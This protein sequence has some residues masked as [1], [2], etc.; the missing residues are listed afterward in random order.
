MRS[1]YL[2]RLANR[3]Y[4]IE[5][6]P[7]AYFDG[8]NVG[9]GVQ[10]VADPARR[11]TALL[12]LNQAMGATG[13]ERAGRVE[14]RDGP[15]AAF[16]MPSRPEDAALRLGWTNEQLRV[17]RNEINL[18]DVG[19]LKRRF[20]N[21]FLQSEDI[22]PFTPE[23]LASNLHG[24]TVR[25]TAFGRS[26]RMGSQT[27]SSWQRH[28]DGHLKSENGRASLFLM[29][30]TDEDWDL[31]ARN[32]LGEL[33]RHEVAK[34]STSD[35]MSM[36]EIGKVEGGPELDLI[37]LRERIEAQI[38]FVRSQS[39]LSGRQM[40]SRVSTG[41]PAHEVRNGRK[42]QLAQFST[43]PAVGEIAAEFLGGEGRRV[44]EPTIG[45][46]V[47][48]AAMAG[49]GAAVAGVEI[50]P[51]RAARAR[52][53]L[54][55]A[56]VIEGDALD[57]ASYP[58]GLFDAVV[59]NPPF[60]RL[61][62][63][64]RIEMATA[65]RGA[66]GGVFPARSK[67]AAVLLHSINKLRAGGDA[68]FVMPGERN[69]PSTLT[70]EK[71][72]LQN[73]LVSSFEEVK[74]ISLDAHLYQAMGSNFPVLVHFARGR[75]ADGEGRGPGEAARLATEWFARPE[76]RRFDG[77]DREQAILF[78]PTA[79]SFEDFYNFADREVL[80]REPA[81]RRESVSP[82]PELSGAEPIPT[83]S[84]GP[85]G[86]DGQDAGGA[87]PASPPRPGRTALGSDP[88]DPPPA[89]ASPSEEEAPVEEVEEAGVAWDS[90]DTSS[91]ADP[92]WY[93]DD[94]TTD[95]FT[96]PYVPLSANAR[97]A[98]TVIERT[99]SSGTS[100]A[101]QNAAL[102]IEG[103]IDAY[104]A[105]KLGISEEA[106]L[107][108]DGPLSPEQIDSLALTFSRRDAGLASI[109]GDQMGVGKGRQLAAHAV[110][111]LMQEDRPVLFMSN[112]Q[113]LFTDFAVRDLAAVSGRSFGEM[114]EGAGGKLRPFIM[115]AGSALVDGGRPIFATSPADQ[116]L[117]RETENLSGYNL[118]M[119]TY[120]QV[121]LA[122]GAW[123]ASALMNWIRDNTEAGRPPI[124]L[125]D[126]VH[127]AAGPD[128]RTGGVI[129]GVVDYAVIHDAPI[130]YSSAT[131]VKSGRNLPVYAP[132][133]PDT[134]LTSQELLLAIDKMPLAMQEILSSEMA[135]SGSLIERKMSDAGVER[136][137]VKLADLDPGKMLAARRA[138]DKVSY[139]LQEMQAASEDI[140]QA[141]R[142]QFKSMV[143]G[144]ASAGSL[145]KLQVDTTSPAT[146]L[147]AFSRYLMGSVKGLYTEELMV[148]AVVNN[149]KAT[150]VVEFTGDSVAEWLVRK[151]GQGRAFT[152]NAE[153][154]VPDHPNMGHVLERFAERMLVVK[155]V[156][157]YGERHDFEIAGF[158]GWLDRIKDQIAE[159]QLGALRINIFDR[160]RE[161]GEATG[162]TVQDISGRSWEFIERDGE[163]RGAQA[164][165]P[166]LDPGRRRLQRGPHGR[167]GVQL[168]GRHRHLAPE[169]AAARRGSP[170]PCDDQDGLPARDHR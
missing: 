69:D 11:G 92:T 65:P 36:L 153:I 132:A 170:S 135:K 31:L 20:V 100:Q 164:H 35:L 104:V 62:A 14:L 87:D 162:Q 121:Q 97:G 145:D 165:D 55:G 141:A 19:A 108:E 142:R 113:N 6:I 16:S 41:F 27:H 156:D 84:G 137:L 168:V 86:T 123:R 124:L 78:I 10:V 150:V 42:H 18:D 110:N 119:A 144:T 68:V 76:H 51:A 151:H 115:N 13:S 101:L 66:P 167:S 48:V 117:A 105:G 40:M 136:S 71:V 88:E 98:R 127:K 53:A 128:S 159:A 17:E 102:G 47:F 3:D 61:D 130:V 72:Q 23:I 34:F 138:S 82:D 107:A 160:V 56:E 70:G 99:M 133:L 93:V 169:L 161:V 21:H 46:G 90:V 91:W 122:S 57:P 67:Q 26:F 158:D 140:R 33:A 29:A 24:A 103:T 147:D 37:E 134:G 114:L 106:I 49:N 77:Q 157:G 79:S 74:T 1:V 50:D 152:G 43:P 166:R 111:A 45:N 64:Q 163:V 7:A 30:R 116:A 5:P 155:G 154:A 28:D 9:F 85:V 95:D 89:P 22:S 81:P 109:I 58:E 25:R 63:P 126:E 54:A 149:E 148:G 32:F 44:L 94:L 143:G 112:R 39:H 146:Q 131:S 60:D 75:F 8:A 125:L 4:R 38:A 12:A 129:R 120:S 80:G 73:M 59:A 139:I 83:Q 118:V 52:A 2:P 96:T 15:F